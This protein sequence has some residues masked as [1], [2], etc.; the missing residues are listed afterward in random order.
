MSI[1]AIIDQSLR[2]CIEA[3]SM[4]KLRQTKTKKPKPE[5]PKAKRP[6]PWKMFE[7]NIK[8]DKTDPKKKETFRKALA[9]HRQGLSDDEVRRRMGWNK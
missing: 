3:E 6:L 8:S 7:A 1:N 4:N 5:K 9:L 2:K